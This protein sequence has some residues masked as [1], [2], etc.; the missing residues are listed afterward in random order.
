MGKPNALRRKEYAYGSKKKRG[1]VGEIVRKKLIKSIID[2]CL[3]KQKY[4]INYFISLC[5]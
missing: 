4:I 5:L 2:Q 1:N 3:G